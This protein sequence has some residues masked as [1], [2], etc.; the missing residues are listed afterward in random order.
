MNFYTDNTFL[1]NME[2]ISF[3]APWF[4]IFEDPDSINYGCFDEW[5]KVGRNYHTL[6]TNPEKADWHVLYSNYLSILDRGL[7][8]KAYIYINLAKKLDKRIIIFCNGDDSRIINWPKHVV[9]FR[10][11]LSRENNSPQELSFPHF[12][13]DI[14]KSNNEMAGL[15]LRSKK[16]RPNV[17]FCGYAPPINTPYNFQKVKD[18]VKFGIYLFF[19]RKS[20]NSST[21]AVR[22][23]CI[24][25]MIF[26]RKINSNFIIR[27]S[28]AFNK[29]GVLQPGGSTEKSLE[30]RI[31]YINNIKESDYVLC[32]R[33]I[34]NSSIRLYES[35]CLGRLPLIINTQCIFPAEDFIN[36]NQLGLVVDEKDIIKLPEILKRFH[37][38]ISND[39]FQKRQIRSRE[40]WLKWLSPKGFYAQ[41]EN[42]AMRH[43]KTT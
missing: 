16:S 23:L 20:N 17:G 3:L 43:C 29:Y 38:S 41:I 6:E 30:Q 40:V 1:P 25:R 10:F 21:H 34:A 18:I 15:D 42:I 33:G 24:I 2:P 32:V 7:I 31:E 5:I 8:E 22:T 13:H 14:F 12:H 9:V 35:L 11:A 39:E 36:Y 26:T 28:F 4:N 37:N 19:K 27:R